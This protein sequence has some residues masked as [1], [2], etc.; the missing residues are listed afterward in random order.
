MYLPTK[1]QLIRDL[2]SNGINLNFGCDLNNPVSISFSRKITDERFLV[3]SEELINKINKI[4][5]KDWNNG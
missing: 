2:K 1:Q 3:L 4:T 5:F